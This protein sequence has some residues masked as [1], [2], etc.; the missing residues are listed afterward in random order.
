MDYTYH[1]INSF[2]GLKDYNGSQHSGFVNLLLQN[3]FSDVHHL[4]TGISGRFDD[5]NETLYDR[6]TYYT[7]LF[8]VIRRTASHEYDLSRKELVGGIFGEYTLN[9]DNKFVL[10]T[11]LRADYNNLYKWLITPRV[12]LKYDVTENLVLRG[13]AGHGYR[14]TNIVSDNIGILATGYEIKI[15]ND[16]KIESAW[17]YGGSLMYYLNL[18]N[19][20]KSYV[21]I[22]YFRTDFSNQTLVDQEREYG[23]LRIYKLQ[24]KS[25]TNTFQIDFSVEPITRFTVSTTFRYND[26]KVD[27]AG[28]GLVETPLRD[29]YKGVLNLQYGTPMYKW[30]FDITAQINGQSRLPNFM[31]DNYSPVYPLF[32]AQITRKFKGTELYAGMENIL[33]YKQKEPVLSANDVFSP[34]F[35]SSVIWGPLMGRRIYAGIRYTL[36]K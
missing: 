27:L 21:S 8:P 22:D 24:G 34:E 29:R 36:F 11:G 35:N 3:F 32:F 30:T 23:K 33:N 28:Q 1:K 7:S 9:L 25:Y 12:N 17:T 15:D 20:E 4:T 10:V 6:W 13:S 16:L 2:F 31:P 18:L 5:Y 19:D 26:N 14:S